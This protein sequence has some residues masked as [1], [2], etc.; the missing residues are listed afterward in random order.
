MTSDTSTLSSASFP[1]YPSP[2]SNVVGN[3]YVIPVTATGTARLTRIFSLNNVLVSPN[4]IKNLNFIRQF[5]SNNNCSVDFDPLVVLCNSSRPLYPLQL[6]AATS[7]VT[8]STLSLWHC[9]LSHPCHEALTKLAPAILFYNKDT[10]TSLYRTFQLGRHIR[11]PFHTSTSS[12][13][14]HFDLIH[15]DLWTSPI[16]IV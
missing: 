1:W 9:C 14:S 15:Y 2:S 5:I 7:L 13:S 16:G 10:S 3:N 11:L 4:L 8:S 12:A 6:P